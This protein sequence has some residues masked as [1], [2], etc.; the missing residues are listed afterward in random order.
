MY[1]FIH[2]EN[3]IHLRKQLAIALDAI[4]REEIL[5]QIGIE[6]KNEPRIVTAR[7]AE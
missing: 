7:N 2:T 4:Q 5:R 6:L 1:R 3:L